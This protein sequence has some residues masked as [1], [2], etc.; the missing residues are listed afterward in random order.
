MC[1]QQVYITKPKEAWPSAEWIG[2]ILASKLI[3]FFIRGYYDERDDAFPQIKV[4][5][6][7]SLPIASVDPS[8]PEEVTRH[9]RVVEMVQVKLAANRQLCEDG[10]T[11]SPQERAVLQRRVTATDRRIDHL[12]YT[13]YGLTPE[14][15]ALVEAATET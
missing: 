1:D 9:D 10:S 2:A 7:K 15:I 6:L 3:G 14:E 11:L 4:G 5:Q 12:V 8:K 13:L